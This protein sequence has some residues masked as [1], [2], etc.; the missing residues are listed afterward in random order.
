MTTTNEKRDN[1]PGNTPHPLQSD[2][3][4]PLG[5]GEGRGREG[6]EKGWRE[7]ERGG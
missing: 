2:S 1:I 6:K 5:G 7:G 3:L 4:G